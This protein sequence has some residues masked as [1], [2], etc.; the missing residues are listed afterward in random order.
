M[1][2][3]LYISLVF[4]LA[5]T[6]ACTTSEGNTA[7]GGQDGNTAA[8]G[9]TT[10]NEGN[11]NA[12]NSGNNMDYRDPNL[13]SLPRQKFAKGGTY[14]S[15][16]ELPVLKHIR[17]DS[18]PWS[19]YL[20][21]TDGNGPIAFYF[22]YGLPMDLGAPQVRFEYM[23]KKLP[24]C[25]SV[26][27]LFIWLRSI[28]INSDQLGQEINQGE[29][30]MTGDG[31]KVDLLTIRKPTQ[32]HLDSILTSSKTMAWAYIDHGERFV[33]ATFSAVDS[34]LFESYLP[35][36]KDLIRSYRAD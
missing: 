7:G 17:P 21:E 22:P 3:L 5:A 35:A 8:N 20:N 27:S 31:Q 34:A 32:K 33:G 9:N 11:G 1:N 12:G 26:D 25:S 23:H 15:L 18:V 13:D 14:F 29:Y 2:R 16:A 30:V 28:F 6:C 19:N 10:L 4:L 24:G 36:F